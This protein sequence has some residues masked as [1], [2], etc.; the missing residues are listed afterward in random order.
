MTEKIKITQVMR[1]VSA[2]IALEGAEIRDSKELVKERLI[3]VID[4]IEEHARLL[5]K[6]ANEEGEKNEK[7]V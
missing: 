3:A 6:F 7:A 1:G 4:L 2:F 5:R